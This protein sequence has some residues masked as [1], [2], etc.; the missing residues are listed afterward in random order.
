MSKSTIPGFPEP[1]EE[2]A[3]IYFL[4]AFKAVI[5]RADRHL[6]AGSE[7]T[8]AEFEILFIVSSAHGSIRFIDLAT[9]TLLSQSRI[10]RQIDALQSKGLVLRKITDSDRRA[11]FATLTPKGRN[12]YD[13]AHGR[14]LETYHADF[15]DLVPP[16]NL[17][18]FHDTLKDLLQ[19]PDYAERIASIFATTREVNLRRLTPK[20]RH[21]IADGAAAPE[22]SYRSLW[23]YFLRAYKTVV[24]RVEGELERSSRL[25]LTEFE[26]LDTLVKGGG[27][28]RF[29][30]LANVTMLSQSRISRQIDALQSKGLLLREITDSDRRATFAR[31]TPA[32]RAAHEKAVPTFLSTSHADFADLI[33]P[34]NR[35]KFT[36][37]LVAL[38]KE[39]D[40][41]ARRTA[42]IEAAHEFNARNKVSPPA[43]AAGRR[44]ADPTAD[45]KARVTA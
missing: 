19:E 12:I 16:K 37:S 22:T 5:D 35:R 9:I 7:L 29:I 26:L 39:P 3:W 8:L 20:A 43:R 14:F 45:R 6:R 23:I 4:R 41:F 11:T 17:D 28:M 24:D 27:R 2:E 32:G 31:L 1:P 13:A 15:K 33:A 40:Y 36:A 21:E 30:D 34:K 42:I 25:A 38:L 18:A 44:R 10:S